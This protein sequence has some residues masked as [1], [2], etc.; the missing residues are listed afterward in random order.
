MLWPELKIIHLKLFCILL[1]V[2]FLLYQWDETL[3]VI[4]ELAINSLTNRENVSISDCAATL[5]NL[6]VR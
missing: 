2:N 5:A 4:S 3:K 1:L 6:F